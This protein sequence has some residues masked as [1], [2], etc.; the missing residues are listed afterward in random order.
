L[1][2]EKAK[3]PVLNEISDVVQQ[4]AQA[5]MA[6]P[7]PQVQAE[8]L[9]MFAKPGE[10]SGEKARAC[11]WYESHDKD[12][13]ESLFE[14]MF[15][16]PFMAF[17]RGMCILTSEVAKGMYRVTLKPAFKGISKLYHK[18]KKDPDCFKKAG[19]DKNDK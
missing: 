11:K 9:S 10:L 12:S 18:V 16:F 19:D 6:T 13:K 5:A 17:P 4:P 1:P 2:K 8:A 7:A 14:Y 15:G 3:L